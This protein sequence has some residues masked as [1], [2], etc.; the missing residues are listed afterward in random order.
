MLSEIEDQSQ[1][2]GMKEVTSWS[3]NQEAAP[4][5]SKDTISWKINTCVQTK[6]KHMVRVSIIFDRKGDSNFVESSQVL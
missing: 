2:L 3:Q 1:D 4:L 6:Y 5:Y